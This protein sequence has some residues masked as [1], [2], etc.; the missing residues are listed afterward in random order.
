MK[1]E[2]ADLKVFPV[3]LVLSFSSVTVLLKRK[4]TSLKRPHY[5]HDFV[6]VDLF[7][8]FRNI[9]EMM[10][11]VS[12]QIVAIIE[13]LIQHADWF[14]PGGRKLLF[15]GGNLKIRIVIPVAGSPR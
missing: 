9:T 8:H 7:F 13:P 14:F 2:A 4:E 1:L 6:L 5:S 12:L 3:F 10:A 11:T 15:Q